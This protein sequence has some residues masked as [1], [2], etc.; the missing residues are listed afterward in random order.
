VAKNPTTV[1]SYLSNC[2][3]LQIPLMQNCTETRGLLVLY[4]ELNIELKEIYTF[5]SVILNA[6]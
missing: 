2:L 6:K 5:S 3:E 1:G 4:I